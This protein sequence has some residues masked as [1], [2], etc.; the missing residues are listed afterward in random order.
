MHRCA[1]LSRFYTIF[2]ITIKIWTSPESIETIFNAWDYL[3][4][5]SMS[6]INFGLIYS[7]SVIRVFWILVPSWKFLS[8]IFFSRRGWGRLL[9]CHLFRCLENSTRQTWNLWKFG[10]FVWERKRKKNNACNQINS[11][12]KKIRSKSSKRKS[13]P[14]EILLFSSIDF[15]DRNVNLKLRSKC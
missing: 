14:I 4:W 7:S 5:Q 8:T 2:F 15:D 13:K 12:C 11:L 9:G 1:L 6:Q 10:F 3:P